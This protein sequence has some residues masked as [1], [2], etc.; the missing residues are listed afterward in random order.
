MR[1]V[2][3]TEEAQAEGL[4]V[5]LNLAHRASVG[6]QE[7][8]ETVTVENPGRPEVLRSNG[9]QYLPEIP[10]TK[11][12]TTKTATTLPSE[13]MIRWRMER[14]FPHLFGRTS[15]LELSGPEGGPIEVDMGPVDRLIQTLERMNIP[16]LDGPAVID[17]EEP[18]DLEPPPG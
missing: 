8:I 18:E 9:T 5:L 15:R 3:A 2:R 16:A 6:G 17:G 7:V 4:Q 13:A 1:F 10:A 14:R 11:T 12:V